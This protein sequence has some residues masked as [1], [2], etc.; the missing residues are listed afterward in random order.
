MAT[1]PALAE[2]FPHRI[3]QLHVADYRC[4]AALPDGAV[5][6]VGS[7][8]SGCQITMDLLTAGREVALATS[9]VGWVPIRYRGLNGWDLLVPAGF[10]HQ[11][12]DE[13]PDPA[14]IH[15]RQPVIAPGG[16]S[17]SL[18][19]LA[20][21]GA[22][23]TGK[24]IAI[25]GEHLH[26]DASA[27]ANVAV[28]DAFA[29]RTRTVFDNYIAATG[30]QAPPAEPDEAD[31][32]GTLDPPPRLPTRQ[33]GSVIWCTGF[34]ADYSWLHP[35]LLSDAGRPRHSETAGPLPGLFYIGLR[36]LTPPSFSDLVRHAHGRRH[37]RHSRSNPPRRIHTT[38]QQ[39]VDARHTRH[40]HQVAVRH[41]GNCAQSF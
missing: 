32:S 18:H 37:R 11:R 10:F 14:M 30:L 31:R 29:A 35:A 13:L 20:R 7:A 21:A 2:A 26:F 25:D 40:Q 24:L 3:A 19:V 16:N 4:P 12:P 33:F 17:L 9:P 1:L 38:T 8:Q 6:V 5:L 27:T 28:S 39:P 34:G 15:A 23:L 41:G 36:W 22:T